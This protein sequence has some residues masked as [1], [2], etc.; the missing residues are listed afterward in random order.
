M[1][2]ETM[3]ILHL[4][5]HHLIHSLLSMFL[6]LSLFPNK[7]K[8]FM[9]SNWNLHGVL[10][11]TC[12]H[13]CVVISAWIVITFEMGLM[14]TRSTPIMTLDIGINLD[15]TCNLWMKRNLLTNAN[16]KWGNYAVFQCDLVCTM[17]LLL[18]YHCELPSWIKMLNIVKRES[19]VWKIL[20]R[21]GK[22]CTFI[23]F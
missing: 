18:F 3:Q 10:V 19:P 14:E 13:L 21:I 6:I 15:A 5:H 11:I 9:Q 7:K 20:S 8:C 4:V 1:H 23:D 17:K 22:K 12:W 2:H 16:Y